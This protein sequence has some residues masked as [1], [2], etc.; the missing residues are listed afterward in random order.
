[1]I[2]FTFSTHS[3][4]NSNE[5]VYG[6]RIFNPRSDP[7]Q[8]A[9]SDIEEQYYKGLTEIKTHISSSQYAKKLC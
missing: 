4:F 7:C 2:P 6:A 8:F 1:M 5:E 9:I 3:R